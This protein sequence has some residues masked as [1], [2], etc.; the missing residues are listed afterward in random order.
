MRW[1]EVWDAALRIRSNFLKK[2]MPQKLRIV[3]ADTYESFQGKKV[4]VRSSSVLEDSTHYSFAG[5]HESINDINSFEDFLLAIKKVWTS[6][7]SDAALIYKNELGLN[8]ESSAMAVVIQ[9]FITGE[10]SGVGF[11]QDPRNKDSQNLVIEAV[12]G[13]CKYLVDGVRKPSCY[14]INKKT[15]TISKLQIGDSDTIGEDSILRIAD[16]LKKFERQLGFAIDVEWTKKEDKLYILQVRPITAPLVSKPAD[17]RPWYLSLT[18][19]KNQ[20]ELL[21][22]KVQNTLIPALRKDIYKFRDE[23]IGALTN[24]QLADT[25]MQRKRKFS[26]W[27]KIYYDEFIPFAH[28]VR[29]F[30]MFYNDCLHP[31][32]PYEFVKLL[33]NLPLL[34]NKRDKELAKFHKALSNS[35]NLKNK[36]IKLIS[37]NLSREDFLLELERDTY[38]ESSAFWV[39]L[40]LFFAEDMNVVFQGKALDDRPNHFL[41]FLLE[42]AKKEKLEDS[43]HVDIEELEQQFF[44]KIDPSYISEAKELLKIAKISWQLRDDDNIL[45]GQLEYELQKAL[46]LGQIE[47]KKSA[48]NIELKSE[49][50]E[51]IAQ[52]LLNP[53][54]PILKEYKKQ[55]RMTKQRQSSPRQMCGQPAS[56]GFYSGKARIVKN[57]YDLANFKLGEI[58]ICDAIEP[59]MTYIIA[60]A[61]AIVERRG[62]M[63]IHGAI[64]AREFSIPCVNGVE[65]V[66][67]HISDG[68]AITVDGYLG[69]VT[70]GQGSF[71]LEFEQAI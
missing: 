62:G 56:K 19:N 37:K 5:V 32:D 34:A 12:E 59:Q 45:M 4:I 3:L 60:L 58:L 46:K 52:L 55:E 71:D 35:K 16:E 41:K 25:I 8:V 31:S 11:S 7:W 43:L 6:L 1:E 63:L 67:D 39:D 17:K 23:D 57:S 64:I 38:L 68:D 40:K 10:T 66:M 9:H 44:E 65:N 20:M 15:S 36:I 48:I 69:I 2:P 21:C 53:E 26:E 51:P 29:Q 47:L 14:V 49:N 30:G 24:N 61:G 18:P 33:K 50:A 22:D 13:Q 27:Q 54:D 70:I 42:L 28:G